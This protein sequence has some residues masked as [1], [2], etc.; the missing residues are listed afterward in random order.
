[1]STSALNAGVGGQG[2]WRVQREI[3]LIGSG[4]KIGQL[5]KTEPGVMHLHVASASDLIEAVPQ[6]GLSLN[7]RQ[8]RLPILHGDRGLS[9]KGPELGNATYYYSLVGLETA[10]EITVNG[11]TVAVSGASWM[12]HEFGTSFLPA[13]LWGGIGSAYN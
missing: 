2:D 13:D 7:L 5:R 11:K 12:D 9:Q 3:R 10:G 6:I 4:W 1:M 8:T